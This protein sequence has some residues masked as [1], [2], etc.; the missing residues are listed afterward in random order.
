MAV[1]SLCGRCVGGLEMHRVQQLLIQVD[2]YVD[3]SLREP[4]VKPH[5]LLLILFF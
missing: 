2:A 1:Y 4:P 5:P 3:I